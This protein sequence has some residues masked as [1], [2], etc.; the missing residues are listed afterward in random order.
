MDT[1]DAAAAVNSN[2]DQ[3]IKFPIND[4]YFCMLSSPSIRGLTGLFT[5]NDN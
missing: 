4:L 1:T 2:F 5:L 3:Y